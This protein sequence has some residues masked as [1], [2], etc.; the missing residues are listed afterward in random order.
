MGSGNWLLLEENLSPDS[1]SHTLNRHLEEGHAYRFRVCAVNEEGAGEWLETDRSVSI[2]R[3]PQQPT[4]P[5]APLNI[6]PDSDS[7]LLSWR[8]PLDDGGALLEAFVLEVLGKNNE[9]RP[10][11]EVDAYTLQYTIT[12]LQSD[13]AY[14]VRVAARNRI[15][16]SAW[17]PSDEFFA[18]QLTSVPGRPQGPLVATPLSLS[19]MALEWQ[20]PHDLGGLP[21]TGYYIEKWN[22]KTTDW[23][24]MARVRPDRGD[25]IPL[26]MIG[27]RPGAPY[28]FRVSAENASGRGLPLEMEEP[29]LCTLPFATPG[30]P[31]APLL[32]SDVTESTAKLTWGP[33]LD[34]GGLD[35]THYMVQMRYLAS[36]AWHKVSKVAAS[37]AE[38]MPSTISQNL[39]RGKEYIFRVAAV[40]DAGTG[41]WLESEPLRMPEEVD[42]ALKPWWVRV[43]GKGNNNVT[44]EWIMPHDCKKG[45]KHLEGYMVFLREKSSPAD[46]EPT[47]VTNV[48]HYVNKLTIAHLSPD[49]EYYF[50]VCSFSHKGLGEK[51]WTED[52]VAPEP[53]TTVPGT[54]CG[55][56]TICKQTEDSCQL[57]W[58]RPNDDGGCPISGYRIFK[59]EHF[60]RSWQEVGKVPSNTLEFNVQY[61]IENTAYDFRVCAENKNGLSEP[62][63]STSQMHAKR[64]TEPPS[65]PRG[66]LKLRELD[67][68][69][70]ELSWNSPINSGGVPVTHYVVERREEKHHQWRPVAEVKDTVTEIGDI[71]E[72][73]G[74]FFRVL[75]INSEGSSLPLMGERTFCKRSSHESPA[76]FD[77]N[78][79]DGR[80]AVAL[81]WRE[82]V[83]NAGLQGYSL[84][85]LD[86]D[87]AAAK[88]APLDFV[89]SGQ[90]QLKTYNISPELPYRFR[91][92]AVYDSGISTPVELTKTLCIERCKP[93][94]VS[95]LKIM[96]MGRSHVDV[97]WEPPS[98]GDAEI[99]GYRL[100]RRPGGPVKLESSEKTPSTPHYVWQPVAEVPRDVHQFSVTGLPV[101]EHHDFRLFSLG[102]TERSIPLEISTHCMYPFGKPGS[103]TR[104]GFLRGPAME[105]PLLRSDY[106]IATLDHEY[107]LKSIREGKLA[108]D[109]LN[110]QTKEPPTSLFETSS[111]SLDEP[112][113]RQ[114]DLSFFDMSR[115]HPPSLDIDDNKQETTLPSTAGYHVLSEPSHTCAAKPYPTTSRSFDS[116]V[117]HRPHNKPKTYDK[118]YSDNVYIPSHLKASEAPVDMYHKKQ[119]PGRSVLESVSGGADWIDSQDESDIHLYDDSFD[120]PKRS[121]PGDLTNVLSKLPPDFISSHKLVDRKSLSGLPQ[122]FDGLKNIPTEFDLPK[123]TDFSKSPVVEDLKRFLLDQDTSISSI[124][125]PTVYAS[126]YAHPIYSDNERR[127]IEHDILSPDYVPLQ[128]VVDRDLNASSP[129]DWIRGS[130]YQIP[131]PLQ[132]II[133]YEPPDALQSKTVRFSDKDVIIPA[134]KDSVSAP[135]FTR[136]VGR[137]I[138]YDVDTPRSL[139]PAELDKTSVLLKWQQPT[140]I[141]KLSSFIIEKWCPVR[142]RWESAEQ[143]P[144]KTSEWRARGLVEGTDYW[145]RVLT[146]DHKGRR[147]APLMLETPVR[148][149]ASA[150]PPSQP[151]GLTLRQDPQ[152]HVE[153]EWCKPFQD[154]GAP[155]QSYQVELEDLSKNKRSLLGHQE[156]FKTRWTLKDLE[157][158]RRYKL[159]VSAKNRVGESQPI[160]SEVFEPHFAPQ[161][162]PS[163]TGPLKVSISDTAAKLSW[164]PGDIA[165]IGSEPSQYLVEKWDSRYRV[166]Q[167]IKKIPLSQME[168]EIPFIFGDVEYAFRVRTENDA[169]LLSAPLTTTSPVRPPKE[170]LIAPEKPR[171]LRSLLNDID[172][173]TLSWDAPRGHSVALDR[174]DI[175]QSTE[176]MPW[177][178]IGFTKPYTR[179]FKVGGL[180]PE[181]DYRFR[182]V[183]VNEYGRSEPLELPTATR[184]KVRAPEP[185]RGPIRLFAPDMHSIHISWQPPRNSFYLQGYKLYVRSPHKTSWRALAQLEPDQTQFTLKDLEDQD[186]ALLFR[187][188]ALNRLGESRP[189]ESTAV[190]RPKSSFY[191][192]EAL[193]LPAQVRVSDKGARSIQLEWSLPTGG[194]CH[195]GHQHLDGFSV[196]VREPGHSEWREVG[197]VDH[198]IDKL[199]ISSGLEEGKSY[200]FGVAARSGQRLSDVISTEEPILVEEQR[201]PPSP[202]EGPLRIDSVERNSLILHWK[203]ASTAVS[204]LIKK[205]IVEKR[206]Q[207]RNSWSTVTEVAPDLTSCRI[208]DLLDGT[209]YEFRVVAVNQKGSSLPL[210]LIRPFR[211]FS[212]F[213]V[214][215]VPRMLSLEKNTDGSVLVWNPPLETGNLPIER[216]IV[217]RR[218]EG[219]FCWMEVARLPGQ[220]S[221]LEFLSPLTLPE[222]HVY[223]LRIS[224]VNSEG[225]GPAA[226]LDTT[227]EIPRKL[228]PPT[229]PRGPLKVRPLAGTALLTLSWQPASMPEYYPV[230]SYRVERRQ[231]F[232]TNADWDIVASVRPDESRVNLPLPSVTDKDAYEYRIIAT[233]RAGASPALFS[234]LVSSEVLRG[235]PRMLAPQID[236]H[237]EFKPGSVTLKW[238]PQKND[239]Y[240]LE[241]LIQVR[242]ENEDVWKTVGVAPILSGQFTS[243]NLPE[244]P[245]FQFRVASKTP[246]EIGKFRE[247]EFISLAVPKPSPASAKGLSRLPIIESLQVVR[248]GKDS[249]TLR[250]R[251]PAVIDDL[252]EYHVEQWN[253]ATSSWKVVK[254]VCATDNEVQLRNLI[255][256]M[257]Y[258][259][260]VTVISREGCSVPIT[261]EHPVVPRRRLQVPDRP[262]YLTAKVNLDEV[263]LTW[264]KSLEDGGSIIKAY[265]VSVFS[266]SC[267]TAIIVTVSLVPL[268][269][270]PDRNV[271]RWRRLATGGGLHRF[272]QHR[273][274]EAQIPQIQPLSL[275]SGSRHKR[276]WGKRVGKCAA[277]FHHRAAW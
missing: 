175:Q 127:S 249:V 18:G 33:P 68:G 5:K 139:H 254:R 21:L 177:K 29:V 143:V 241:Y 113:V 13:T 155:L 35:L 90:T 147:S 209:S 7:A 83:Q 50:G 43:I 213:D 183:A 98:R 204:H 231:A 246:R 16:V 145:F 251:R 8:A 218:A 207:W 225:R 261:L 40:N 85:K 253:S 87:S 173:I 201:Q 274:C 158:N 47:I 268:R 91:I 112:Q 59:R 262:L 48:D 171:T 45:H 42:A 82:P 64:K 205:Y 128:N 184:L 132:S 22:P 32:V 265:E 264:I 153:A 197:H 263:L 227:I 110:E 133:M 248:I 140:D 256:D 217:E 166:W 238:Q 157:P 6:R 242:R 191:H 31:E 149:L 49:K 123:L 41:A 270:F 77:Y 226:L 240:G 72:G 187:I 199:R 3:Q 88:W 245:R 267:D 230:D 122:T 276:H 24:Y 221:Q 100:E 211:F 219:Q 186:N 51:V 11:A 56:L 206:E 250:W 97:A 44:I 80:R 109:K 258:Y 69:F 220:C 210:E 34:T 52:A 244:G 180:E 146:E 1:T 138:S 108:A 229:I 156:A 141:S 38:G 193:H 208:S 129:S 76:D 202:P 95:R 185:P 60:R 14:R 36:S 65:A 84:E 196:F 39:L 194:C 79:G 111:D 189:L 125:H 252:I 247:L 81:S 167:P 30:T 239:E 190:A 17:L 10:L 215:G 53:Q 232:S 74:Y 151:W 188:T 236:F 67:G 174:Y 134:V 120:L 103:S 181:R 28:R 182:I 27:L 86:V 55:P 222:G 273:N 117:Q 106:G 142:K 102:D 92:S 203:P 192:R 159:I 78:L 176:G 12:K 131:R 228:R 233:N 150:V 148:P 66:P 57:S 124:R 259:Y 58:K 126:D 99:R 152:G 234:G 179:V 105:K 71:R 161:K 114:I 269:N 2:R 243:Y 277:H 73:Q 89:P 224:A 165:P 168:V 62:L 271:R 154:G 4:A 266:R 170:Q 118:E 260:R 160:H 137:D 212:P 275:I 257:N 198:F 25:E 9:W 162:P 116:H 163:P 130:N 104:I 195:L 15:G 172:S 96:D 75:A 223:H 164:K 107:T 101:G 119:L 115:I 135:S 93:D 46:E 216:Y 94:T 70:V 255:E 20:P 237:Y 23:C 214:P 37:E 144:I 169:G 26:Q 121:Y 61:L 19:G 235:P 54:P 272:Q 136:F 178:S 200:F 63:E